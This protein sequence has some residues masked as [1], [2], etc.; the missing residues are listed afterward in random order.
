MAGGGS[1][2]EL[3]SGFL[4]VPDCVRG[5][6]G[7]ADG[8][9]R[10]Q[11]VRGNTSACGAGFSEEMK[12]VRGSASMSWSDENASETDDVHNVETLYAVFFFCTPRVHSALVGALARRKI[13]QSGCEVSLCAGGALLMFRMNIRSTEDVPNFGEGWRY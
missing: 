4:Q 7:L 11:T 8:T 10:G 6:L 2:G 1:E 3:G 5:Q 9:R 12:D 13:M